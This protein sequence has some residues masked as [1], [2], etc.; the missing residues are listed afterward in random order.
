MA[1]RK[2]ARSRSSRAAWWTPREVREAAHAEWDLVLDA[3]ACE[4]S[5]LV[6]GSWLGP[7]HPD[8]ERRDALAFEHWLDLAEPGAGHKPPAVW[9]N[10]PFYPPNILRA[11]LQRAAA[12]RDAGLTVVALIP[13]SV[14][15]GWWCDCVEGAGGEVQVLRGRLRFDGPFARDSGPAP[16]ACAMVTYRA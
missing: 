7:S 14:G 15:T 12:T 6:P 10:P 16:W 1:H 2:R 9:V 11:F 8:H 13:A 3:A 4:Q 5:T